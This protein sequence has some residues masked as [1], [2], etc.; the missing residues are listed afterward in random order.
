MSSHKELAPTQRRLREW[1]F[2]VKAVARRFSVLAAANQRVKA[3]QLRTELRRL[4]QYYSQ[5]ADTTGFIYSEDAA[6]A[7]C[8]RRMDAVRS[9]LPKSVSSTLRVF[10]VGANRDQDESGFLQGLRQF[11]RVTTFQNWQGGYGLWL[12][13]SYGRV[14]DCD[15]AIRALNEKS[16]MAQLESALQEGPIDLLMGQ[17][18][19]NY[20]SKEALIRVRSLGIPVV[21]ISMDDRLPD[22]WRTFHG[23][24][25]GAVGIAPACDLVLT[26]SNET[27]SWYGL[28]GCPAVFWPLASDPDVFKPLPGSLRDIDVLFI[29]NRYGIRE[30]II[31]A[32]TREGVS[33]DCYGNGWSNGPATAEQSAALSKRARI[34]L[35]IGTVGH[36]QDVYTM[37]LRDFDAPMA[38][39]LYLTHRSPDLALLYQEGVEI[40]CYATPQEAARKIGHYLAHLDELTAIAEAGHARAM[41][42][43]TWK[44]RL[45]TTFE[46]L[47]LLPAAGR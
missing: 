7:E 21:N 10:W 37:K 45:Q 30:G 20:L 5:Q 11:A 25:K 43:D 14:R 39:A 12:W 36:C 35:G 6:W 29:G 41:S 16:L 38:G 1:L 26:T 8:C 32:L 40:E 42:R 15:P 2:R 31:Q 22:N 19:A 23:I 24:R 46:R 3:W 4:H 17:M 18:W 13:D 33:V 44:H 28:E 27:C 9:I 34:I 47:G